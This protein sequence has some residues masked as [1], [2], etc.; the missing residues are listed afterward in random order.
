ML[1]LWFKTILTF[2][3]VK[4]IRLKLST[5]VISLVNHVAGFV[6]HGVIK[7]AEVLARRFLL[8][9]HVVE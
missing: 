7:K 2:A 8:T 6:V 4:N 5:L 1:F 9:S 3:L